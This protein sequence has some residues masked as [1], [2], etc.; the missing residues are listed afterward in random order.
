MRTVVREVSTSLTMGEIRIC[1]SREF[2]MTAPDVTPILPD[3]A[4]S[5]TPPTTHA[6]KAGRLHRLFADL[7]AMIE[8]AASPEIVALIPSAKY[9]GYAMAAVAV[10]HVAQTVIQGA[11]TP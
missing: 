6:E 1:L 4:P 9:R 11:P 2:P 3:I 8:F 5:V 7:E 10:E